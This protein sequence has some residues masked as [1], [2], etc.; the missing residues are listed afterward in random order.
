MQEFFLDVV[1]IVLAG[2]VSYTVALLVERYRHKKK[3]HPTVK[4][5]SER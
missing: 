2:A 5:D 4:G 1:K 3:N